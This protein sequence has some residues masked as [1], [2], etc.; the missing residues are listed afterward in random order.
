MAPSQLFADDFAAGQQFAGQTRKL[1]EA[2]FTG[3][4]AVT[5]DAH[6][7]H[8]DAAYAARTRFGKRLAHGLLVTGVTALG[9]TPLSAR[10]EEAMIAFLEQG[11]RFLAP[12]LIDE[13]LT[14]AFTVRSVKL[15]P[16]KGTGVV[17]FAIDG[18]NQSGVKVIEG[19]HRYLL[20]MR[21]A[22]T[23]G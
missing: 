11:M 7:L 1:G 17:E 10:L 6:P 14:T 16:A 9:A 18:V 23:K 21:S 8:Y 22:S 5:G 3:F 12:V 20:R 13:S 4:A 15:N 19:F 2:E